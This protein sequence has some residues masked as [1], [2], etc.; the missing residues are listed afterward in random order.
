[1]AHA[2][3]LPAIVFIASSLLA[4]MPFGR[5][6]SSAAANIEGYVN[7]RM[8]LPVA[9]ASVEVRALRTGATLYS[10]RTGADGS[11]AAPNI[12]AGEYQVIVQKGSQQKVTYAQTAASV[13]VI[14]DDPTSTTVAGGSA[15]ASVNELQAPE[16]ARQAL[17]KGKRS[18]FKRDFDAAKKHFEKALRAYPIYGVA[19]A[20]LGALLSTSDP[21]R[22]LQLVTEATQNDPDNALAHLI[23]AAE[24]N[25]GKQLQ[26]GRVEAE[27]ALKRAPE[28]WQA[29]FE[30]GRSL[31]GLGHLEEALASMTRADELSEYQLYR[32]SWARS[33]LLDMLGR[34]AEARNTIVGWMDRN[35][36]AA[37]RGQAQDTLAAFDKVARK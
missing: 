27:E 22:S 6:E 37:E 2:S 31:A 10:G 9:N 25:N 8:G 24:L 14:L 20:Y 36:N 30:R 18:F 4:Q 12:P 32:I 21:Q 19:K 34:H 3:F 15:T 29:H 13:R 5:T 16:E 28:M 26:R 11:F 17:E 1:M 23:L 33:Q 35:P 7:S